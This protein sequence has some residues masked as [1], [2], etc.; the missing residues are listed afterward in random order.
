[1]EDVLYSLFRSIYLKIKFW[2]GKSIAFLI[3]S[4]QSEV[5]QYSS[6]EIMKL[7]TAIVLLLVIVGLLFAKM[8]DQDKRFKKTEEQN[9]DYKESDMVHKNKEFQ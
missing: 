8:K 4:Q 1:M 5:Q 6:Y 3:S 9:L 2:H 7:Y